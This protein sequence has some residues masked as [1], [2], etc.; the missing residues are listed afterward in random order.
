MERYNFL[1]GVSMCNLGSIFLFLG[2]LTSWVT[3]MLTATLQPV[4]HSALSSL[5]SLLN[6][7]PDVPSSFRHHLL[8]PVA[9]SAVTGIILSPLDLSRTRLVVQTSVEQYRKY[10]GPLDALSQILRDEGGFQG[11][12]LHPQ[13]LYPAVLDCTLRPL[14][15][16][17]VPNLISQTLGLQLLEDP[18]SFSFLFTQFVGECCT[19]LLTLPIET[20]R[21][22]LQVQVRGVATPLRPCVEVRPKPY[23]GVIDAIYSILTEERSDVPLKRSKRRRATSDAKGK[24]KEKILEDEPEASQGWFSQTGAAQLY[25]GLGIRL[26]ASAIVFTL[27]LLTG[28]SVDD[29]GWTEL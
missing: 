21:R 26:T 15:E 12:Y 4:V 7:S 20:V 10:S 24:G 22:R 1:S 14:L 8:L 19:L 27:A 18:T 13:L 23:F 5:L 16:L 17:T 2:V 29:G 28:E 9:S 11:V 6:P 25:R 3:Q